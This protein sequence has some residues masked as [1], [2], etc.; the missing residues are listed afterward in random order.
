[1]RHMFR[2]GGQRAGG[3]SARVEYRRL[4]WRA[5]T[6][7]MRAISRASRCDVFAIVASSIYKEIP[8][9]QPETL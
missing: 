8:Y 4:F 1:M 9:R 3:D 6:N 7:R 2:N 5:L